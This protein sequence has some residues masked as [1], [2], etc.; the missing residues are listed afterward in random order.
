MKNLYRYVFSEVYSGR[1]SNDEA[2]SLLRQDKAGD[3]LTLSH[4]LISYK[5]SEGNKTKFYVGLSGQEDFFQ[6]HV[7]QNEKTL[8]GASILE[9]VRAAFCED[10]NLSHEQGGCIQLENVTFLTPIHANENGVDIEIF[11]SSP[12]ESNKHYEKTFEV[13]AFIDESKGEDKNKQGAVF[14]TGRITYSSESVSTS[15][16]VGELEAQT[17]FISEKDECYTCFENLGIH[18]GQ[19]HRGIQKIRTLKGAHENELLCRVSI[20]RIS[21]FDSFHFG[22]HPGLLD[23]AF[24][25]LI[26]QVVL[27]HDDSSRTMVPFSIN[28]LNCYTTLPSDLYV[29]V[30]EVSTSSSINSKSF[31]LDVMSL[32]GEL[33]LSVRGFN[34][35][36]IDV[37]G[38]RIGEKSSGKRSEKKNTKVNSAV[39]DNELLLLMPEWVTNQ[40]IS[41]QEKNTDK[42][43]LLLFGWNETCTNAFKKCLPSA[44]IESVSVGDAGCYETISALATYVIET[45]KNITKSKERVAL[46]LVFP[47]SEHSP[48]SSMISG[49]VKAAMLEYKKLNAK[50][51]L[52]DQTSS[53]ETLATWIEEEIYK[54]GTEIRFLP[55]HREILSLVENRAF[56]NDKE[57]AKA[58]TNESTKENALWRKDGVYLVSG[59][60][61]GLGKIIAKVIVKNYPGAKVVLIGRSALDSEKR[62]ALEH[63][64]LAAADGASVSYIAADVSDNPAAMLLVNDIERDYG[65]LTGVFHC[66]GVIRDGLLLTKPQG[67]INEVFQPKIP[68][69]L[70]LDEA[71]KNCRLEAFVVFS[72]TSAVFGNVGQVDYAAAN[73]FMDAYIAHRNGQVNAGQRYGRSLSVN[74]PLWRDGGMHVSAETEAQMYQV[75]GLI[76]LPEQEGINALLQAWAS[77]RANISVLYGN[78]IKLSVLAK[79][80]GPIVRN[81]H[82]ADSAPDNNLVTEN[83]MATHSKVNQE[84]VQR[85]LVTYLKSSISEHLSI[86]EPLIDEESEF[87]EF[88]FDSVSI[89]GFAN[90]LN[91]TFNLDLSPTNFFEYPSVAQLSDFLCEDFFAEVAAYFNMGTPKENIKT[92][93][94]LEEPLSSIPNKTPL[95]SSDTESSTRVTRPNISDAENQAIAIVGISGKFPESPDLNTLWENLHNGKD[96]ITEIPN[97]RWDWHT[98]FGDPLTETNKT[99]IKHAGLIDGVDEFDPWFFGITPAEAE[100]MDPQQRLL[101]TYVWKAIED[102]GHAPSSLAGENIGLFIATGSSGY[103][104]LMS[105]AGV[106]VEG[107]SAAGVV[108]SVGPNRMSFFLDLHGPSEPIETACSSSLVA[109]HRAV[110]AIRAGQCEQAVVGGVNLL[111]SPDSHI[112]FSKAGMLSADG[113]CKTF[114]KD[115]N[116][117]VRGE[118]V[119][120]MLIKPL[121]QAERDGDHIYAVIKGTA[122]NHGGRANS[123]TA[124][125]PRAQAELIKR[126]IDDSGVDIRT[127][128][129]IEAHGTGTS[130]GDPIEIQGLKK[131]FAE[132]AEE[133]NIDLE[134]ASCALGSI[135]TNIGHLEL[136][137]GIAGVFKVLLQM[138]HKKIVQSLHC[139]DINPY[140]QIAGSPFK[141]ATDNMEWMA[142]KDDSGKAF[143]RR[144]GVSSFGFG[145]VNA[146][147]VLEEYVSSRGEHNN[148]GMHMPPIIVLSAKSQQQ[149]R[150][151][152]ENLDKYL[153]QYQEEIEGNNNAFSLES[154][155][156]TLQVGRDAMNFR[157]G[158]VAQDLGQLKLILNEYLRSETG[159]DKKGRAAKGRY[160]FYQE[161]VKAYKAL[162]SMFDSDSTFDGMISSWVSEGKYEK[163]CEVWVKGITWDWNLLYKHKEVPSRMSLPSYPFAKE[164]YWFEEH[165]ENVSADSNKRVNASDRDK[166]LASVSAGDVKQ[167]HA[168]DTPSD[169]S[170]KLMVFEERYVEKALAQ[171]DNIANFNNTQFIA[172]VS[173]K[174]SASLISDLFGKEAHCIFNEQQPIGHQISDLDI[175][176]NKKVV[177]LYLWP[178]ENSH[179]IKNFSAIKDVIVAI[180]NAAV[181]ES[182]LVLCARCADSIDLSYAESW[183]SLRESLK[184]VAPGSDVSTIIEQPSGEDGE[185]VSNVNLHEFL[186]CVKDEIHYSNETNVIYRNQKRLVPEIYDASVAEQSTVAEVSKI[187]SKIKEN[188]TYLIT[189]GLGGVGRFLAEYLA[190]NYQV[191]LV[192]CG[193][194]RLDGERKEFIK[195]IESLGVKKTQEAKEKSETKVYYF[196]ADVSSQEDMAAGIREAENQFGVIDGVFHAAGVTSSASIFEKSDDQFTQVIRAKIDGALILDDLLVSHP[197]DFVCYFS[198]ISAILGDVGSCDYGIANRFLL[199]YAEHREVRR[200]AGEVQGESIAIAWPLWKNGGMSL[201][202]E[203]QVHLYLASSGQEALEEDEG[204]ALIESS[205]YAKQ[206]KLL[207]L[208]GDES[209]IRQ[210]ILASTKRGH[211]ES[212]LSLDR[213]NAPVAPQNSA[214]QD[215]ALQSE[216][217]DAQSLEEKVLLDITDIVSRVIKA[218][219]S[220]LTFDENL[221]DFGFDSISLSMLATAM[222]KHFG[223]EVT[224]SIFFSYSTLA[225]L[226]KYFSESHSGVLEKLYSQSVSH[227]DVSDS[228]GS[229]IET[230]KSNSYGKRKDQNNVDDSVEKEHQI[231]DGK[232][233]DIAII[234]MSGRFPGA[235]NTEELWRILEEGRDAVVEIPEER[236]NWRDYYG[237]PSKDQNKTNC[238]WLG[239]LS[240]LK[241]FDPKFFEISP[242][243]AEKMDPRQRLLLQEAWNALEDAGYGQEQ[244]SNQ[245]IGM[246]VGV[247][248]GEYQQLV[249]KGPFTANHDGILAARLAYIMNLSGPVL[250]INTACSSGLVAAHEA[251]VSLRAGDC[252]AAIAG[253]VHVLIQPDALIAMGHAGM[254]S[255]DG[256]C[257]TFSNDANGMVPGEAVVAV[258]LKRL[259]DAKRDGDPIHGVIAG[260]GINY[261]GKT[262]GI[263]APSGKAQTALVKQVYQRHGIAFDDVEHFI[264]H[265][266]GTRLGDPIEVNALYDAFKSAGVNLNKTCALTSNKPNLGHTFAASGIVNL[267]SMLL[268]MKHEAIPASI[269]CDKESDYIPWDKSPFYVNKSLSPWKKKDTPRTGA[270]SAYGICGTNA[271]VVVRSYD[272]LPERETDTRQRPRMIVLSAK[273]EASL[274]QRIADLY[275]YLQEPDTCRDLSSISFTLLTGRFHFPLRVSFVAENILDLEKKLLV[276]MENKSSD[277][278]FYGKVPRR[279]SPDKSLVT[280]GNKAISGLATNNAEGADHLKQISQLYSQ[281]YSFDWHRLFVNEAPTREHLPTYPFSRECYWVDEEEKRAN[282]MAVQGKS[283]Q[284]TRVG[285]DVNNALS[286]FIH[287]NTSSFEEQKFSSRFS[288]E[289]FFLREHIVHGEKVMPGVAYLEMARCALYESLGKSRDFIPFSVTNMVILKPLLVTNNPTNIHITL[290]PDN[291]GQVA[292]DIYSERSQGT[293]ESHAQG[294]LS[295]ANA[296]SEKAFIEAHTASLQGQ[297]ISG[298]RCYQGF[299]GMGIAHGPAFRAIEDIQVLKF[300]SS[301]STLLVDIKLPTSVTSTFDEFLL[302][303]SLLDGALQSS[304]GFAL[305]ESN[306]EEVGALGAMIPFALEKVNVISPLSRSVK[307]LVNTRSK[308]EDAILKTDFELFDEHG[309]LCVEIKGY[310]ARRLQESHAQRSTEKIKDDV[311]VGYLQPTW[312]AFPIDFENTEGYFDT[313]HIYLC[314][315]EIS[316]DVLNSCL[317]NSCIHA[318]RSKGEKVSR[319]YADIAEQLFKQIQLAISEKKNGRVLVQVVISNL[320]SEIYLGLF[321]MLRCLRLEQPKFSVQLLC[322]DSFGDIKKVAELLLTE[323]EFCFNSKD[324]NILSVRYRNSAR[325]ALS[326]KEVALSA[327]DISGSSWRDNAVYIVTG[328]LGGLGKIFAHD[329][330]SVQ[331]NINVILTGRSALDG[332][333]LQDFNRLKDSIKDHS[334][335]EYFVLDIN[336]QTRLVTFFSEITQKYGE[337]NGVIHSAGLIRDN[338]FHLKTSEEFQKVLSPKVDALE[339]IDE[340]TKHQPLDFFITFSSLSSVFGNLGQ[341]DYSAANGFMDRFACVRQALVSKGERRGKTVSI[342]WPLWQSGGMQIQESELKQ[343]MRTT[344]MVPMPTELGVRA[345]H[346]ALSLDMPQIAVFSGASKGSKTSRENTASKVS[347]ASQVKAPRNSSLKTPSAAEKIA[348]ADQTKIASVENAERAASEVNRVNKKNVNRDTV[349]DHTVSDDWKARLE[350]K[351]LK[352]IASQL[353]VSLNDIDVQAEFGELGFDSVSLTEFGNALNQEYDIELA[354]TIFFEHSEIDSFINHLAEGYSDVFES[355]YGKPTDITS[356]PV[357]NNDVAVGLAIS[358]DLGEDAKLS[359]LETLQNELMLLV[360]H[361]LKAKYEDIDIY[362]EFGEFGFDSVSLTEFGNTIN[363]KYGIEIPPTIFFECPTIDDLSGNI[364]EQYPDIFE[365]E[366]HENRELSEVRD[367]DI[368]E[369]ELESLSASISPDE[370]TNAR[371]DANHASL[372][373]GSALADAM[374]LQEKIQNVL[375]TKICH[376]LKMRVEDIDIEDEFGELGFDSVSLTELANK[377][378]EAYGVDLAPTVFFECPTI[379]ALSQYLIDNPAGTLIDTLDESPVLDDVKVSTVQAE[380][381][382][383]PEAVST[384]ASM[385][386]SQ[387][388]FEAKT[389]PALNI[390][391]RFSSR[392]ENA[393]THFVENSIEPKKTQEHKDSGVDYVGTENVDVAIVGISGCFPEAPDLETFWENLRD[394]KDCITEVP[395]DRWDWRALF[396]DPKKEENK[397]NIKSAGIMS[398]M[399]AFD[400]LFFGISPREAEVMDPQQRL[401]LTYVWKAIEDAGHAPKSL[402]GSN[403]GVYIGT[404]S[405]GYGSMLPSFGTPIEGFSVAAM[406]GSV[407]PNRISFMLNLHGP[408]EPIETA[409]SSSLV[410][411]HRAVESIILGHCDQAIAGGV[412]TLVSPE[413]QISF[414]KA[415]MLSPNGRCKTFSKDADGYVRGEGV[416]MLMLKRLDLAEADGDHIYAV[417]KASA[418]N[419]GG[420]A[421]SLTAPNPKAQAELIKSALTKSR[422]EPNSVS[423]IEAHGTGT[424]LG[425][426]IEIQGLKAA[427]SET[428]EASGIELGKQFCRLGSVKSNI[429]HLE[430]AAGVA[431]VIKVLLQL[432]HKQIAPSLHCEN[433]N[434][435]VDIAQSP[436]RVVRERE[437]WTPIKD[438]HGNDLPR[439]AGVSS[440]GFGGVNAHVILEEYIPGPSPSASKNVDGPWLF[441]LS[442]KNS[443]QRQ[444]QVSQLRDFLEANPSLDLEHLAY[445]LQFGRDAMD[446]RFACV[447]DSK[448]SLIQCLTDYIENREGAVFYQNDGAKNRELGKIFS[449]ADFQSTVSSW[450][451]KKK[452]DKLADIWVKGAKIDWEKLYKRKPGRISIPSYP[453][454][455][456]RYW[457]IPAV[458]GPAM[459]KNTGYGNA[460]SNLAPVIHKNIS[461]VTGLKFS[462]TLTGHEPFLADHIVGGKKVLPAVVYL[463]MASS[464]LSFSIKES[465]NKGIIFE[466]IVFLKPLVVDSK[467]VEARIALSIVQENTVAF[468]IYT[469]DGA[470]ESVVLHAQG[471]INV[472]T[473]DSEIS[474]AQRNTG[475]VDE[476]KSIDIEV[477]KL[478][479]QFDAAG[480]AYGKSHRAIESLS[481]QDIEGQRYAF[482]K[483]SSPQG[484][485]HNIQDYYVCPGILDAALQV[486]AAFNIEGEESLL[487]LPFAIEKVEMIKPINTEVSVSV[488]LSK[489]DSKSINKYNLDVMAIDGEVIAKISGFSTRALDGSQYEEKERESKKI[490]PSPTNVDVEDSVSEKVADTANHTS[491]VDSAVLA[492]VKSMLK[493][494]ISNHLGI[495]VSLIDLDA[496]LSEF[497]FDSVTLTGYGDYLNQEYGFD[498]TPTTFFEFPTVSELSQHF[499]LDYPEQIAKHFSTVTRAENNQAKAVASAAPE[500]NHVSDTAFDVQWS[501]STEN[502]PLNFSEKVEVKPP[503]S[504]SIAIVGVSGA[505]PGADDIHAFWE[506]II[507]GKD[508]ITEMPQDRWDW[509]RLYGDPAREDNKTNIK[510][511]GVLRGVGEFDPLFFGVSPKEALAMDPQQRILMTYVWKAIEDAGYAPESLSGS[512]TGLFVGTGSS[513]YGSLLAEAGLPIEGYSAA[514]MVGSVG[515][516]RM[517]FLLNL[518]GPSEP[519]ETACSSSL[520]AI[521]RAVTAMRVGHCDQ[522]IVGGVNLMVT[523]GAHISFSKA[524]MLSKTGR[525]RTFSNDADGYVRGEGVGMLFLKRLSDAEKDGDD[526]Y[527]VIKGSAENHGGRSNSLTAPN[528]K[529]Q[530]SVIQ[531]ALKDAQ[532]NADTVTYVEA[533]GTGTPLGDPVEIQGLKSA[534]KALKGDKQDEGNEKSCAVGSVK[535]NIGHLELAAGVAGVIKVLMQMKHKKLA[536]SLHCGEVNQYISLTDSP[537][538]L[539]PEA[540]PWVRLTD[541]A[542]QTIPRRAGVSSF[543]FGGVN[544]HLVLEEYVGTEQDNDDLPER[545]RSEHIVVLSAKTPERLTEN[546]QALY[547]FIKEN[548]GSCN[549]ESLAYTLQVGRD[550]MSERI[551]IIADSLDSLEKKLEKFVHTNSL[552]VN[553]Y[554]GSKENSSSL[555]SLFSD[556]TEL[557]EAVEKWIVREKWGK[558]AEFWSMGLNIDWTRLY[559]GKLP[560]RMHLP[561][562]SFGR[563]VYWVSQADRKTSASAGAEDKPLTLDALSDDEVDTK[564]EKLSVDERLGEKLIAITNALTEIPKHSIRLD[565]ALENYGMDSVVIT[566][567]ANILEQS[568]PE[569]SK[570][571]FY[572][573]RT[574]S[575]VQRELLRHHQPS[576]EAWISTPESKTDA[577]ESEVPAD[578]TPVN[579]DHAFEKLSAKQ[580]QQW[581]QCIEEEEEVMREPIAIIGLDGRYPGADNVNEFWENLKNG[582]N[583]ITEIPEERWSISEFFDSDRQECVGKGKSYSK[584]GGFVKDV[585]EF[586]PLLFNVTPQ[587][588]R[589]LDPQERIFLQ[590]CWNTLEDAGY[591]RERLER[592]HDNRVGV[593]VGITTASFALYGPDLWRR[594]VSSFPIT[595]FGSVANRV[596][597]VFNFNGPSMPIDTMC[598]ASLTAIHEACENIYRGECELALAGG[599]NLFLHPSSYVILCAQQ[600]LSPDGKC[601]S[602]GEG[603]NGFVPGEGVGAVLLK[604]LSQAEKDGDHIYGVI[605]GTSVNHGG[606]TSGYTVPNPNAQSALIQDALTKAEVHPRAVSYIEAHGTGTALGD[607]IEVTGLTNAFKTNTDD[608]GFCRLGSVKTNIGHAESAAG[609]AGLTKVLMQMKHGELAPSLNSDE[610]NP[611]IEFSD[612]PFVVQRQRESWRRPKIDL[613]GEGAQECPRIAGI[614]SFGAG[615]VNAHIIVEEYLGSEV[616]EKPKHTNG[617]NTQPA[618]AI[619]LSAKSEDQLLQSVRNLYRAAQDETISLDSLS[620]TLQVGREPME[621]RIGFLASSLQEV[622]LITER[623]IENRHLDSDHVKN[624]QDSVVDK[625]AVVSDQHSVLLDMW[626]NGEPVDWSPLWAGKSITT[627]SLPTYPFLKNKFSLPVVASDVNYQNA[628]TGQRRL[629]DAKNAAGETSDVSAHIGDDESRSILERVVAVFSNVTGVREGEIDA[630]APIEDYGIDSIV[631]SKINHQFNK[632]FE[633]Y[634]DTTL[635]ENFSIRAVAEHIEA[636]N[637]QITPVE[638]SRESAKESLKESPKGLNESLAEN[639]A[640]EVL[641]YPTWQTSSLI[642]TD[643]TPNTTHLLVLLGEFD[644]LNTSI[645]SVISEIDPKTKVLVLEKESDDLSDMYTGYATQLLEYTKQAIL[646]STPTKIQLVNIEGYSNSTHTALSGLLKSAARESRSLSV[647]TMVFN[648]DITAK[649]LVGWL[650]ENRCSLDEEIRY[651]TGTRETKV[652]KT[653]SKNHSLYDAWENGGVYLISGGLGALGLICARFIAERVDSPIIILMGRSSPSESSQ[654]VIQEIESEGAWVEI[655]QLDVCDTDAVSEMVDDVVQQY[656]GIAGV[657]HV[658][659][660]LDDSLMINKSE[661][662]FRSVL[663]PK[664]HGLVSLDQATQDQD[665][666]L[667][668]HFSSFSGLFGNAG[669][670]DYASANAFMDSY[671]E[672][673]NALVAT[674]DRRGRSLSINWPLWDCGGMKIDSAS[675]KMQWDLLGMLPLTEKDGVKCLDQAIVSGKSQLAVLYGDSVKIAEKFSLKQEDEVSQAETHANELENA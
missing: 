381:D 456:D 563:D 447:A 277:V 582:V 44:S 467:P 482:A 110:S 112:S 640:S 309:K 619:V 575:D 286:P 623:I 542:G 458:S 638:P 160:T 99:N 667:F 53:P 637:A 175:D 539:I 505:F 598:S 247:E 445:T 395:D 81:T 138:K 184:L 343:L 179:Y 629:D 39:S 320:D 57:R 595:S 185:E 645:I 90:G 299:N 107:Y 189:G 29:W 609:I 432:K 344:G 229:H 373:T 412:N 202:E 579:H 454:E 154:L 616:Q 196:S 614:S 28:Q 368:P 119:G 643:K 516:N 535:T 475:N 310:S 11:L 562:Y 62:H 242:V 147:I 6:D 312:R 294:K 152:V 589:D 473:N 260:S 592:Q 97:E 411:I 394:G 269:H 21:P 158:C 625:N 510:S 150:L 148:A 74:W 641:A 111:V 484:S 18:Y 624:I 168:E 270:L 347:G 235:R 668:I 383:L 325:E 264:A 278:A 588:A 301:G 338:Y 281:G 596:S 313:S 543:G 204:I 191:N 528:P 601:K 195:R 330:L 410:A 492:A 172:F 602:F 104:T 402:D 389:S 664:V 50:V 512:N 393:S 433:L 86:D 480:L 23:S 182:H 660:V 659:G 37:G 620:Y 166:T 14:A 318:L 167:T 613:E 165:N 423:Y 552:D 348:T 56:F 303:P 323:Q 399:D 47:Y 474:A 274:H 451:L 491:S 646:A 561:S 65:K 68:G 490:I 396:G 265:G 71:T 564:C 190:R 400:P 144:A 5:F 650:M 621:H 2:L 151:Q 136:A 329:M 600:M 80:C 633:K 486:T 522:A 540:K 464:A 30:R 327:G 134:K 10:L 333:K 507:S 357:E 577:F 657:I 70:A 376:Q 233:E 509:N 636:K 369:Q 253:G 642:S 45:I 431:G 466:N 518:H 648:R 627:I 501:Q 238:K 284:E 401:I 275:R 38:K 225:D 647:Q 276:L 506:N 124:P 188:G 429:G 523:P 581:Q 453:F 183:F 322:F 436:F 153:A 290:K 611:S 283:F 662:S 295:L 289:E 538:Y 346:D 353:K 615:G 262:N 548:R 415:G 469:E 3:H 594:G 635:Y 209:R 33:C 530:A 332:E 345:L 285:A 499:V 409:C 443:Q 493:N 205:L 117:Y 59:G 169:E 610:L 567:F 131:A 236:F 176:V 365:R 245:S 607:P 422:I 364:F 570:T 155:A 222:A 114:S 517:S 558:L 79:N 224:P 316:T 63:L 4:P 378:N 478:Y 418:E 52:C 336:D 494:S 116:G 438:K 256:K 497:G 257:H 174:A 420:K 526:I 360:S 103:S 161:E 199:S 282:V 351:V 201:G 177:V 670:A 180:K 366:S 585:D 569:V 652:L 240:G 54:A 632:M 468:Q 94:V 382:T 140:L 527:A 673:R 159:G 460:Q 471:R 424:P 315:T 16:D 89:T 133:K 255:P 92:R 513:D 571:L 658:A 654:E 519:I 599:V 17:A 534:F 198:S 297:N 335:V 375:L 496:E 631:V 137:A 361:Q 470:D 105:K 40:D 669:Q 385:N 392:H 584:W 495:D 449:D 326:L 25:C 311:V 280:E 628:H 19:F 78:N 298:Q 487:A 317:P 500:K 72:S 239:A 331:R 462:V 20:P 296:S 419:H 574:L 380:T 252:D 554:R 163:L 367:A 390:S 529:A 207:V 223:V 398:G 377:L 671:A 88:G 75:A 288:G 271:H 219:K 266:T 258:V 504:E 181:V 73:A 215:S 363:Q 7:V 41:S 31:D 371:V 483:L 186:S 459:L 128:N 324:D 268:A 440:F 514:G 386:I 48:E 370:Q 566:K 35:R 545:E 612:T 437:A 359:S 127:I 521:H 93:E 374:S 287:K 587:V 408:S 197:I 349:S 578:P 142:L 649:P 553:C 661:A 319:R 187:A 101:M 593:F 354:P 388:V 655:K 85:K 241:E 98:L 157:W 106:P 515:P 251:C 557:D 511:A 69:L 444:K 43:Q 465:L 452:F 481:I 603:G 230:L 634:S 576:C 397:T 537:F 417:V 291:N 64:N 121:H 547:T 446:A 663:K 340:L 216:I 342:N 203:K 246:F 430:L 307:V 87:S 675:T 162:S 164:R 413:L 234:G 472:R 100:V 126:A 428:A 524:G 83:M 213:T 67:V 549:I 221:A 350:D 267:V 488:T 248:Q 573:C 532:I 254:L 551:S 8:A 666:D 568:F 525:C 656:G 556:D 308:S 435:Y 141:V 237:D 403:T 108:S 550:A 129:F 387:D 42:H 328:G 244:I 352:V 217:Q 300:D 339:A 145:G 476:E 9:M 263:T 461:D 665:I 546:I 170:S 214:L 617:V 171:K 95:N 91:T 565:E 477:A 218:D 503:E 541:D 1:L 261:D 231:D 450:L 672:Y 379:T 125:N 293:H 212:Q 533:H 341:G 192:L 55:H 358:K 84:V 606:R 531:S 60:L 586:D 441:V 406:S 421:N 597:Y 651:V 156:Y 455:T 273:S 194:S 489:G 272:Q 76:P 630:D 618:V 27:G 211:Y 405:S 427:F 149:L 139:K 674:G 485:E 590:S 583:S 292:F 15:V 109:I 321:G 306:A 193:K 334:S 626:K 407:G 36:E 123:L 302:H 24:Q 226:A 426:P 355:L 644:E 639:T 122:E 622:C 32:S 559:G 120:M 653:L 425:D 102:A 544:A 49:M 337:I 130:L 304:L 82:T 384:N 362:A 591:N 314:D 520:V 356:P 249:H 232:P 555:Q 208:K 118:G 143:P 416:G 12:D 414:S 279:F 61:G 96:C 502:F 200:L 228:Q 210:Y 442:A 479:Q 173:N 604:R 115:A 22:F 51:I 227:V 178:Y 457:K 391:H 536:P 580:R 220:R 372:P 463:E 434:P 605:R 132:V 259:S 404:A 448:T 305:L 113:R 250:A 135:K 560:K 498:L 146:H 243:E 206:K 572:E 608:V 13:C 46:H 26:A 77:N 508:C 439:R 58:S 34:V 66:A